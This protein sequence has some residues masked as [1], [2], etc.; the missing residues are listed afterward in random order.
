VGSGLSNEVAIT[1]AQIAEVQDIASSVWGF[2]AGTLD[3]PDA[4]KTDVEEYAIKLD[5]NINEDHRASYRYS[6]MEQTDPV[7][8]GFGSRS[9][10]LNSY[11]YN[12][13][14]TFESR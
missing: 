3:I 11:W 14:K 4:L 5:W 7:L 12:Q 2:D 13:V 9:L 6:K 10:S 1:D 8:P